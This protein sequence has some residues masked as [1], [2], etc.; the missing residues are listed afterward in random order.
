MALASP[1]APS[2]R[3]QRIFLR[4]CAL[5]G[6]SVRSPAFR[7]QAFGITEWICI[8]RFR[9]KAGLRTM[10]ASAGKDA[11]SARR[12]RVCEWITKRR[13][14]RQSAALWRGS[15]EDMPYATFHMKYGIWHLTYGF[16]TP[17]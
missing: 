5:L 9:L 13:L 6:K 14:G 1:A 15:G 12:F 7:P 16:R 2:N 8:P 3:V 11:K 10:K 4:M 17:I